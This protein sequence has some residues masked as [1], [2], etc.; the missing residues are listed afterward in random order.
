MLHFVNAFKK[1]GWKEE[2]KEKKKRKKRRKKSRKK[3][4]YQGTLC[5]MCYGIRVILEGASPFTF[6]LEELWLIGQFCIFEMSETSCASHSITMNLF[7]ISRLEVGNE[8]VKT[9]L[10]PTIHARSPSSVRDI[11]PETWDFW[12]LDSAIAEDGAVTECTRIEA[13][14]TAPVFF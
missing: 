8:D 5:I 11:A 1:T 6:T 10:G 9:R 3:V 12:S 4:D 13:S 2:K 7:S 14:S